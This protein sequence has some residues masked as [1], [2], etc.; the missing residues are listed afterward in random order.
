MTATKTISPKGKAKLDAITG[1][2]GVAEP[3]PVEATVKSP[4]KKPTAE[5]E[6][7]AP[8]TGTKVKSS[9]DSKKGENDHGKNK[10]SQ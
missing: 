1:K 5:K 2:A 4:V 9:P 10:S 7:A 8:L 3:K 6:K